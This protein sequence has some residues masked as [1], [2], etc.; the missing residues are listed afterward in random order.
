MS[1]QKTS[2]EPVAMPREQFEAWVLGREHPTY[3]WLDK[4]WLARGDNPDTYAT[5]YVQGLWVA[6]LEFGADQPA[7]VAMV[8]YDDPVAWANSKDLI[9]DGYTH[10]FT[11]RSEQPGNGYTDGGVPIPLYLRRSNS[12]VLPE[13]FDESQ[14]RGTSLLAV[15]RWNKCLDEVKRLNK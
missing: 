15:R 12:I 1:D 6:Y 8:G 3:G 14:Y 5:E 2:V 10:S 9:E 11:V 4:H 13:R 7:P